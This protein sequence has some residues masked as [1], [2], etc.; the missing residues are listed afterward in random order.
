MDNYLTILYKTYFKAIQYESSLTALSSTVKE[1]VI[2]NDQ[3]ITEA[4]KNNE[5]IRELIIQY[6]KNSYDKKSNN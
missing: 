1:E 5:V 2:R 4:R 6:I 3:S